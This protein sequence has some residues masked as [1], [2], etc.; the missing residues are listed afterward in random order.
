MIPIFGPHRKALM[1]GQYS[2]LDI[3]TPDMC[4]GCGAASMDFT[5]K[6]ETLA[7]GRMQTADRTAPGLRPPRPP[8][9]NKMPPGNTPTGGINMSCVYAGGGLINGH[10]SHI[11]TLVREDPRDAT[12]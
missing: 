11:I 2:M 12:P 5:T 3:P 7:A 1:P 9:C 8:R 4:H 6:L 10:V